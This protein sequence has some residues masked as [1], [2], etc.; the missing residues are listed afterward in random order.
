MA[1]PRAYFSH[2][3]RNSA[4]KE[5]LRGAGE[6][7]CVRTQLQNSRSSSFP[8]YP[9]AAWRPTGNY[10]A[11][12]ALEAN[13]KQGSVPFSSTSIPSSSSL[14]AHN[15]FQYTRERFIFQSKQQEDR[16]QR[17]RQQLHFA[18]PFQRACRRSR[19]A[20]NWHKSASQSARTVSAS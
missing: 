6:K 20:P 13:I 12:F 1:C 16:Q 2:H 5:F 15:I 11:V 7:N 3:C 8:S 17:Q 10:R 18:K 9:V 4:A 14:P 19:S